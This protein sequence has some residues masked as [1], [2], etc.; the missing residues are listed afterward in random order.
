MYGWAAAVLKKRAGEK[1][2]EKL[3][4][5]CVPVSYISISFAAGFTNPEQKVRD[6]GH[7][8]MQMSD[9]T[10]LT[11]SSMGASQSVLVC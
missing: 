6:S 3:D 9:L 5:Q 1:L 10:P 4:C 7:A 8:R 2:S 11:V